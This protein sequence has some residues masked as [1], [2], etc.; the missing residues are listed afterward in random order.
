MDVALAELPPS[1]LTDICVQRPQV[2]A[3]PLEPSEYYPPGTSRI[4]KT[5]TSDYI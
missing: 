3:R 5:R 4:S 1:A 2:S